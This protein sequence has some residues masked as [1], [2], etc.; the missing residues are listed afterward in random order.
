MAAISIISG[1]ARGDKANGDE[2]NL[3][4]TLTQ[5]RDQGLHQK[6]WGDASPADHDHDF[7]HAANRNGA[8]FMLASG[9]VDDSCAM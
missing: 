7:K 2:V 3:V 6:G 8:I 4:D 5:G 1:A 9:L